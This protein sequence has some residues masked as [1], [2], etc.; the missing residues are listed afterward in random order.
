MSDTTI[1]PERAGCWLNGGQ[2]WHNTYRIVDRAQE[3]GWT[4]LDAV[5]QGVVDRYRVG[6]ADD[7]DNE[8]MTGQGGIADQA[9]DYLDGLTTGCHFE[10]DMGELNLLR[11]EDFR[12]DPGANDGCGCES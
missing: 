9:F 3:W 12:S 10:R 11:C 8:M 7:D 2:G 5:G 6:I 1:G 4:E